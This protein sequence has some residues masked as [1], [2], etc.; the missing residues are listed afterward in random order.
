MPESE[1]DVETPPDDKRPVL[2]QQAAED[3]AAAAAA[4][5][6]A[7]EV[8]AAAAAPSTKTPEAATAPEAPVTPQQVE[9]LEDRRRQFKQARAAWVAVKARAEQDLEKVKDGAHMAY[10]ADPAQ[11]PKVVAGCKAIDE[12]LDNLDDE[13][14][15]TLD[16]YA[17]TPLRN[18][19]KLQALAAGRT[20]GPTTR[21][22]RL[23]TALTDFAVVDARPVRRAKSSRVEPTAGAAPR[24]AAR[25][26]S[27][28][29]LGP[30]PS[31]QAI[32]AAAAAANWLALFKRLRS[33]ASSANRGTPE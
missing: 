11:F 2:A 23:D 6:R 22:S 27:L 32:T 9:V 17:S 14:R 15:D 30:A 1:P 25:R 24:A 26:A 20:K 33:P 18:Q 19:R 12:I 7:A 29:A 3:P 4:P 16:Q 13:L 21:C 8:A 5:A 31:A 28:E 10:I